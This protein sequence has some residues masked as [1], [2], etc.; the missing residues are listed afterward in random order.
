MSITVIRTFSDKV[1]AEAALDPVSSS[2]ELSK[3][4]L[5]PLQCTTDHLPRALS[6]TLLGV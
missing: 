5:Y 4:D 2:F 6:I 3:G 1:C